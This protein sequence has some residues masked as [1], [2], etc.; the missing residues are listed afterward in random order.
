M[1]AIV[2]EESLKLFM[3]PQTAPNRATNG[4]VA[5]M[6]A[7]TSAIGASPAAAVARVGVGGAGVLVRVD[8]GSPD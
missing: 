1:A 8:S 2:R 5:P 4:A 3:M 7:R 6:V